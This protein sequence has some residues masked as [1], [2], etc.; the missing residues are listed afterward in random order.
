MKQTTAMTQDSFEKARSA[1]FG[2]VKKTSS[3][4]APATGEMTPQSEPAR[5]TAG[6][7]TGT[8]ASS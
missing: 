2:N 1:F 4:S 8:T 6:P 7:L 5:E 3:P